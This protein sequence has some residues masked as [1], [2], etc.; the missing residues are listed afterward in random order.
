[1]HE[2]FNFYAAGASVRLPSSNNSLD[3]EPTGSLGSIVTCKSWNR[4]HCTS[5]L[6]ICCYEHRCSSCKFSMA[7]A[8]VGGWKK[9]C[10]VPL[11]CEFLPRKQFLVVF[12]PQPC[13]LSGCFSWKVSA[14]FSTEFF[15]VVVPGGCHSQGCHGYLLGLLAAPFCFTRQLHHTHQFLMGLDIYE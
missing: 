1:M 11:S 7:Q 2:L 8:S 12:C 6:S 9:V 3:W 13:L 14:P 4:G 5:P 15:S 10:F